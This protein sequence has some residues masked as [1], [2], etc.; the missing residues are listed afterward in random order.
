MA[1]KTPA[2]AGAT[3]E[4]SFLKIFL[5]TP[6]SPDRML[7]ESVGFIS[8]VRMFHICLSDLCLQN[9]RGSSRVT[10][11]GCRCSAWS[12][13]SWRR[14]PRW[15]ATRSANR[16]RSTV[17]V[18]FDVLL[19]NRLWPTLRLGRKK[20]SSSTRVWKAALLSATFSPVYV[21]V[22]YS[23]CRYQDC[24]CVAFVSIS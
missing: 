3:K 4:S 17:A 1:A 16:C 23:T 9:W 2:R 11:S 8:Q 19:Q 15:C 7:P 10:S 5:E 13:T 24:H 12:W 21:R 6:D 18:M 20:C 22:L 14:T